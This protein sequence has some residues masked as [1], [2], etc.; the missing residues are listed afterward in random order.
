V[1]AGT[2]YLDAY[3]EGDSN[4]NPASIPCGGATLVVAV[5]LPTVTISAPSS[6]IAGQ[7]LSSTATLSGGYDPTGDAQSLEI[8]GTT[9][10][11]CLGTTEFLVSSDTAI[12]GDSTYEMAS[13]ALDAGTYYIYGSYSGNANN[14]AASSACQKLVVNQAS[15]DLFLESSEN[16]S[17]LGQKV[18]FSAFFFGGYDPTGKITC[19]D[20][21]NVIGTGKIFFDGLFYEADF[22]T[23]DLQLG[24]HSIAA[25]YSGDANNTSASSAP[26][27]QVVQLS[28]P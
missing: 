21:P 24:T 14:G 27:S 25:S 11:D 28:N 18:E 23:K 13:I 6:L 2:Y 1:G 22:S 17:G 3:Y 12:S 19:Y 5:G 15:P 16:P 26:L 20:G 9:S 7:T 8:D 4:N 10:P